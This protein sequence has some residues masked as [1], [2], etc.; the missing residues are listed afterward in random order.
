M[1]TGLHMNK[2]T[3]F[4]DR[5]DMMEQHDTWETSGDLTVTQGAPAAETAPDQVGLRDQPW[6]FDSIPK[7]TMVLK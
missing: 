2:G 1:E 7:Q 5:T 3:R 6:Y 4:R